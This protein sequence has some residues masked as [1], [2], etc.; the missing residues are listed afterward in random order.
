ML[1]TEGLVDVGYLPEGQAVK[2]IF[3]APCYREL[4]L[5]TQMIKHWYVV[6]KCFLLLM[7]TERKTGNIN[8]S[9]L[10]VVK[11]PSCLC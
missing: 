3:F 2:L 8:I 1:V 10:R 11:L 7:L 9:Y 6:Y 5:A 4:K